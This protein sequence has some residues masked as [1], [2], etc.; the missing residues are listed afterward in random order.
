MLETL[1]PMEKEFAI[2]GKNSGDLFN[3]KGKLLNGN[4]K[5][6]V[7]ISRLLVEKYDYDPLVAAAVEEFLLPML[8]YEPKLRIDAKTC[9]KSSWLWKW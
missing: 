4:P 5:G 9:L 7:P 6:I 1:G 3:K 2:N 8:V